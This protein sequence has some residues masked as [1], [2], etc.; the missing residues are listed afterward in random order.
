[1]GSAVGQAGPLLQHLLSRGHERRVLLRQ[2]YEQMATLV[3]DL[4]VQLAVT[5]D[6]RQD[7]EVAMQGR[8]LMQAS[9]QM[10]MLSLLY[11]PEL[12]PAIK[13]LAASCRALDSALK[14]DDAKVKSAVEEFVAARTA[15]TDLISE[16]ARRYT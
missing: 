8:H 5:L 2:K 9:G 12:E 13:R 1:M 14:A 4:S 10:H 11:F 7:P 3:W 6:A 16:Y 15:A